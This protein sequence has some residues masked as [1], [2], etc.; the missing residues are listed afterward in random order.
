MDEAG[1]NYHA[2]LAQARVASDGRIQSR[3]GRLGIRRRAG[4]RD[5]CNASVKDR[6]KTRRSVERVPPIAKLTHQCCFY[7]YEKFSWSSQ[8]E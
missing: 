5:H 8:I 3:V 7:Q 4:S 6:T 2:V 1:A